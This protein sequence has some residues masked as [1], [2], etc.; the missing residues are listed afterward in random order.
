MIKRMLFGFLSGCAF[1]RTAPTSSRMNSRPI[2]LTSARPHIRDALRCFVDGG[3]SL[4]YRSQLE[5]T[6]ADAEPLASVRGN[7]IARTA[8]KFSVR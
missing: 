2:S 8:L 5:E 7:G 6:L 4:L 3:A 1:A